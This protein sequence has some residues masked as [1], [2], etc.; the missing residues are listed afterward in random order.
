[1]PWLA[2]VQRPTRPR[3][4][5]SVL[6]KAEVEALLGAMEGE[7]ALLGKLLYGTGV[8]L[9]E[10]LRLRVKDVDSTQIKKHRNS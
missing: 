9:M 7:M 5:P 2:E 4:I 10:G 6:T 8:R 3:R 1:L